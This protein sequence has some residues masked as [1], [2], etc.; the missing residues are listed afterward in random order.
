MSELIRIKID[1]LDNTTNEATTLGSD[2]VYVP[3]FAIG[4]SQPARSPRLCTSLSDFERYFG[5]KAPVF[6]TDQLYPVKEG[7]TPG[8]PKVAIPMPAG[9]VGTYTWFYAGSSD[10]SYTYAKELIRAGLPVVYE[11]INYADDLPVFASNW[12]DRGIP[13]YKATENYGKDSYV[14]YETNVYIAKEDVESPTGA[15]AFDDSKWDVV[16]LSGNPQLP[17]GAETAL[18]FDETAS[19]EINDCVVYN[20]TYYRAK[21][22]IEPG[23]FD[24]S[25]WTLIDFEY[26]PLYD[27]NIS[28]IYD[29]M[30][31][32]NLREDE[33][34]VFDAVVPGSLSEISTYNIKYITSGGYPTF[35]YGQG[36][37][38]D[39]KTISQKMATLAYTRG[40]AIAFIDHT[41]NPARP[42]TGPNSVYFEANNMT[43]SEDNPKGFLKDETSSFGAMITP[44]AAYAGTDVKTIFMPGSYGYLQALARSLR[45]YP[46]YLPIAGVTRGVIPSLT[47]LHTT[48]PL[49]NSIADSYQTPTTVSTSKVSL[50]AITYINDQG[51]V[52]WGNR[53]LATNNTG[54]ATTFLNMR[55]LVC[56]VKKRAFEAAQRSLFEQNTDI[57]WI[58]FKAQISELIDR[59]VAN[60]IV[61]YY[62]ILRISTTDRTKLAAKIQIMPIYAVETVEISVVLTDE[63]LTI[64]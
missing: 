46:G 1:E 10:P 14:V 44:W 61:R 18:A 62:K 52:L 35:E 41:D 51:Y 23:A 28:R 22:T 5:K 17:P 19:Y 63:D 16:D 24:V 21:T 43:T 37:G 11:R 3:G 8:F 53:T 47:S 55:N 34:E 45:T 15:G 9:E 32:I 4:G 6:I 57:L 25:L 56:D 36:S 38:N 26:S 31:G 48:K 60:S 58:N 33:T 20:G 49:T 54:F 59:M 29:A 40:D 2:I 50:N 30:I 42:L 7:N 27:V 39:E 13:I 64:E 12:A